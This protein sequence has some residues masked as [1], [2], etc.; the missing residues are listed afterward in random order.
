MMTVQERTILQWLRE[1]LIKPADKLPTLAGTPCLTEVISTTMSDADIERG[2]WETLAELGWIA[3][4]PT[5]K[6]PANELQ[7]VFARSDTEA[8]GRLVIIKNPAA[9]GTAILSIFYEYPRPVLLLLKYG[10]LG[11]W[12][13]PP[14]REV[15]G[16]AA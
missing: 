12:T 7:V 15:I 11:K 6:F 13:S 10:V 3:Y 16:E 9:V 4:R 1:A 14:P 2:I 5:R 8:P